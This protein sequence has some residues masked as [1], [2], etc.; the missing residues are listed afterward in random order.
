MGCQVDTF[1]VP[2]VWISSLEEI[3]YLR[4]VRILC[5]NHDINELLPHCYCSTGSL[6]HVPP[7]ITNFAGNATKNCAKIVEHNDN[8]REKAKNTHK[9]RNINHSA[10]MQHIKTPTTMIQIQHEKRYPRV[11]Q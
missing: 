8:I 11:F 9:K 4:F 1:P 7:Y 6:S 5:P 2:L 10:N 3:H